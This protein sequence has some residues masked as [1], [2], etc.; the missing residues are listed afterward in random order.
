MKNFFNYVVDTRNKCKKKVER[1]ELNN[2]VKKHRNKPKNT[3]YGRK[4][5]QMN[6]A[7]EARDERK[8]FV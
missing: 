5:K 7:T 6:N 2:E 1:R 4:A 8:I 3:Y